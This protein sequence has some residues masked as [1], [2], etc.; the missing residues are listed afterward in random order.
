MFTRTTGI[1]PCRSLVFK[2]TQWKTTGVSGLAHRWYFL[3]MFGFDAVSYLPPKKPKIHNVDCLLA[4]HLTGFLYSI[5]I[6]PGGLAYGIVHYTDLNV[7]LTSGAH[8]LTLIGFQLGI[9]R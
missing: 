5:Y 8:A 4:S 2:P 9:G 1:P 6:S 7:S 3:L